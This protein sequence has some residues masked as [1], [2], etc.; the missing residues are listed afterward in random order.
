MA[1]EVTHEPAGSR[2][3]LLVDGEHTGLIDYQLRDDIVIMT[4]TE[5]HPSRRNGGLG[6]EL[7][8]G[9]LDDVRES[10]LR[11]DPVC[12]FVARWLREHPDYQ[13]LLAA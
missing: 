3:M 7:V 11:V 2:Y 1:T 12:P 5:V 13:D 6:G 10:G 8:R 9:A 4:H